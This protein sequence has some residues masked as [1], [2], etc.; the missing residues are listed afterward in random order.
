M[1]TNPVNKGIISSNFKGVGPVSAEM[2]HKRAV[3]L[4]VLSGRVP[5]RVTRTEYEQAVRELTG[6]SG[7]DRQERAIEEIPESER[8]DPVPGSQGRP[9]PDLANEDEDDGEG[10]NES[11]RLV[12]EGVQDAEHDQM[13]QAEK[14][15][16][17]DNKRDRQGR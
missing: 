16:Q 14:S 13:L 12:E 10:R 2:V 1:A 15:N 11:A 4:A 6:V 7:M 5:P 3:E 8:W 9:G 17:T